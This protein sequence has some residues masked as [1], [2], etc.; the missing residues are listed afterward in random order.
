MTKKCLYCYQPLN[1]NENGD[2]HEHCS[3]KFYGAKIA[4][5]FPYTLNQITEL[6]KSVVESS[7][8]VPGVQAKISLTGVKDA[9]ENGRWGRLTVTGALGGSYIFKPPSGRYP[10]LPENEHVTTR[11]AEEAFGLHT[12]PSSLIRMASGELAHITK[13]IDRTADGEKIHMLDMF[14]ILEAV[15]KYKGSME[16]VG[17]AVSAYSSDLLLDQLSYFELTLFSYLTGNNDMHLKNFSMINKGDNWGLAPAYDLLN[18][19]IVN[20][21]DQE[22]F[23]LTL[24]GKKSK[25]KPE[26]FQ[27]FAAALGLT[28]KQAENTYN[29]FLKGKE[30]AFEWLENSFLSQAMIAEY[31]ALMDNRYAVLD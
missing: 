15:D 23:A 16:R 30:K 2:Y 27:R 17:K 10:E 26:H 29:R 9:L 25:I 24:E 28:N 21:K 5:V 31:K 8:A 11:M 7:I 20:P 12:V 18:V 1:E 19:T 6:A 14:Q 3:L 4:P 13:R 22:E